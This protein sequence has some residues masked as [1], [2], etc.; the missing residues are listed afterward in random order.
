METLKHF[1][2]WE[3]EANEH[4][5]TSEELFSPA[6]LYHE[7]SKLHTSDKTTYI[8]IG[9]VNTSPEIRQI[10]TRPFPHYLGY[11][12]IELPKDFSPTPY[13]F[14]NILKERRSVHHFSGA[15]ISLNT[16]AKILYLG[17]GVSTTTHADDGTDWL[18]RTAPSG[19]GLF[20]IDLY[21]IALRVDSLISGL[22]FYNVQ[23]HCLERLAEQDFTTTLQEATYLK[24]EVSQACA[25]IIM[26]AV[27]PRTKFKYGE[28][29]YRFALLETGHIAQNLLL[30]AQAEG[31]GGLP[32]GGFL[33]DRLNKLL[34]L[35][36]CEEIVLY[37]VLI[38]S[39]LDKASEEQWNQKP[40]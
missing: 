37:L 25:C 15:P 30:A 38:G 14:E 12:S 28:R 17:D 40:R 32:V 4:E 8:N 18:F 36:G 19:G 26:S 13:A 9:I 2:E 35:D 22:Y 21:C 11:P 24:E 23:H 29:A 39:L 10:I 27:M 31:L 33:D 16:L 34:R 7:N 6:E 1:S 5:A 3:D 20:P